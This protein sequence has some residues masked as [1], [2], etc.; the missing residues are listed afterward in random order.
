M[1]RRWRSPEP[2]EGHRLENLHVLYVIDLGKH[3]LFHAEKLRHG[4]VNGLHFTLKRRCGV[5]TKCRGL[6]QLQCTSPHYLLFHSL[7]TDVAPHNPAPHFHEEN[8]T[9]KGVHVQKLFTIQETN[10]RAIFPFIL[11]LSP[12]LIKAVINFSRSLHVVFCFRFP[13]FFMCTLHKLLK[14]YF[15]Y[16]SSCDRNRFSESKSCPN[17]FCLSCFLCSIF[18]LLLG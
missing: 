7:S 14:H 16:P 4:A 6:L 11:E 18:P 17:Q 8:E 2:R 3:L 13:M 15:I 5:R 12:E 10:I 9:R 1:R